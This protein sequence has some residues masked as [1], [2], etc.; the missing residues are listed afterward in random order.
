MAIFCVLRDDT[1]SISL[2]GDSAQIKGQ[3]SRFKI[4]TQAVSEFPPVPDFEGQPDFEI[5]GGHLKHLIAQTLFAAARDLSFEILPQRDLFVLFLGVDA[6][7]PC[8]EQE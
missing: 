4:Y 1:L 8:R 7:T 6:T 5:P 2:E 3:D